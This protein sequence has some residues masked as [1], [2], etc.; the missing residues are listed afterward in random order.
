MYIKYINNFER[1]V[2]AGPLMHF[3]CRQRLSRG[4][5]SNALAGISAFQIP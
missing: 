2:D 4:T 1:N 5:A 3:V